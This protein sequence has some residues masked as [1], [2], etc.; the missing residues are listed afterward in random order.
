M[1]YVKRIVCLAN[2]YKAPGG[3]CIAGK[4]LDSGAWIRP[5]SSR[6]TC[7]LQ[8]P[9]YR[10]ENWTGPKLLDIVDVPLLRPEAA[11]QVL[12][13]AGLQACIKAAQDSGFSR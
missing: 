8:F 10:Y 2:S 13:G 4:E 6:A 11:G 1:S 7:E 12:G 3:R 9:E 5:I